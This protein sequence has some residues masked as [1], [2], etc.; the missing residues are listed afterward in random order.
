MSKNLYFLTILANAFQKEN[1]KEALNQA[2]ETIAALGKEPE[3]REGFHQFQRFMQMIVTKQLEKLEDSHQD[4]SNGLHREYMEWA[5]FI[6]EFMVET[7]APIP[8]LYPT[9]IYFE[10][11][12]CELTRISLLPN[13]SQ[14]I[15]RLTPGRYCLK[16]HTGRVI[17]E[18]ELYVEDFIW[19]AA[20]PDQAFLLAAD[21]DSGEGQVSRTIPMLDGELLARIFPGIESGTMEIQWIDDKHE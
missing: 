5:L 18:G 2:F 11:D 9:E 14:S 1:P 10:K 16:L 6:E 7:E 13:Q 17:W 12:E 4:Q 21:T 19:S 15:S 3:Y 20:F 8:F